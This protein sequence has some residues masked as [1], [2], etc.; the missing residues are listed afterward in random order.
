MNNL[1]ISVDFMKLRK[2][3]KYNE[4]KRKNHE[5]IENLYGIFKNNFIDI[6][7]LT[8]NEW[9]SE[10]YKERFRQYIYKNKS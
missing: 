9:N 2:E 1:N 3:V 6:V 5:H 4:W 7:E 8:D 10:E